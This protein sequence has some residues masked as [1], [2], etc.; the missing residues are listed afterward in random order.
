MRWRPRSG[1]A[2]SRPF[3]SFRVHCQLTLCAHRLLS[4]ARDRARAIL[5]QNERGLGI[6]VAALLEYQTL[7]A[8]QIEA[9][10]K[11]EK[12]TPM[13]AALPPP[14]GDVEGEATTGGRRS[15]EHKIL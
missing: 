9:A 14:A 13:P 6:V 10:L 12:I 4:E 8:K 7:S 1:G 15:M 2:F 5:T 3:L 11:G